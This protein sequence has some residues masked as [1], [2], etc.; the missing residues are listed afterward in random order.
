[1]PIFP[2]ST[3]CSIFHSQCAKIYLLLSTLNCSGDG[4]CVLRGKGQYIGAI[5]MIISTSKDCFPVFTFLAS[6]CLNLN[7]MNR[8]L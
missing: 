3:V 4:L 8:F 7:L 1:V 5:L 2:T 6:F